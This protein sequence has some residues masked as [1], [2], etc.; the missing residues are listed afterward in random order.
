MP[1]GSE[2]YYCPH[3]NSVALVQNKGLAFI[4]VWEV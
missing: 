2:E 3:C 1:S 4:I